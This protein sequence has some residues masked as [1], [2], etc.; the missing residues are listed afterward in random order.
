MSN[1]ATWDIFN[2]IVKLLNEKQSLSRPRDSIMKRKQIRNVQKS[3]TKH[4][5]N[6]FTISC[7]FWRTQ[8]MLCI[9]WSNRL[10]KNPCPQIPLIVI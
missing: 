3:L 7:F 4:L 10:S 5:S 1:S 2:L 9:E 6:M 8:R